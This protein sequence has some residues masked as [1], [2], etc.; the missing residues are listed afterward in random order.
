MDFDNTVQH[1]VDYSQFSL[2]IERHI[3]DVNWITGDSENLN[4]NFA[5]YWEGLLFLE[6]SLEK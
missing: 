1:W 3:Y 6:A 4:K 5:A 2:D